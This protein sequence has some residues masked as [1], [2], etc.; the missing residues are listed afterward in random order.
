MPKLNKEKPAK[1]TTH[2][3]TWQKFE[4]QV[5][6]KFG[7][8]RTPLSGGDSK[9]TR[10]DSLHESLFIECK[11]AQSFAVWTLFESTEEKAKVENKTPVVA[12][13][14]KNAKGFLVVLKFEDI[15]SVS[16]F[17]SNNGHTK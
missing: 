14:K 16:K 8:T 12:L 5:A 7:S 3:R 13:K 6:E 9:I 15:E 10:S 11:L 17:L 2:R 4:Q 1:K